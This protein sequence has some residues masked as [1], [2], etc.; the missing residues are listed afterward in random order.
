MVCS[1]LT[2]GQVN[3]F[4]FG[5]SNGVVILDDAHHY[6]RSRGLTVQNRTRVEP[7]ALEDLERTRPNTDDATH[8]GEHNNGNWTSPNYPSQGI[9]VWSSVDEDGL[10]RMQSDLS[11]VFS[12]QSS[13]Q[14]TEGDMKDIAYTLCSRRTEFSWRRFVVF[15]SLSDLQ[16]KLLASS[17]LAKAKSTQGRHAAFVF[18][19]QG[20]QYAGMGRGLKTVFRTFRESMQYNQKLLDAMGCEWRLEDVMYDME[21][22]KSDRIHGPQ[23][24][25]PACTALQI[26]LVDLIWSFGIKPSVVVGHSSGEIAAA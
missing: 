19:G 10:N 7:P 20:A 12:G 17:A 25:Q 16:E 22:T 24:S 21:H 18:T 11:A 8:V 6:P 3:S 1:P 14:L 5:G 26:A 9:L 4:G 23:Y 15:S 2:S 13:E